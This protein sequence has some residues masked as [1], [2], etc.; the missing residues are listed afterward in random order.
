LG[1]GDVAI[2]SVAPT[3]EMP[4]WYRSSIA[5]AISPVECVLPMPEERRE[6]YLAIRQRETM[7]VVTIIQTLSPANKRTSTTV[8]N[9]IWRSGMKCWKAA[10]ISSSWTCCVAVCA[11]RHGRRCR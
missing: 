4:N 11:C 2:L 1:S 7:E 8:A 5:T 9:N 10:R 6:T 3:A